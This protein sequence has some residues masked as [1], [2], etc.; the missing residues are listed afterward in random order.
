MQLIDIDKIVKDT[1]IEL[2][3]NDL[4]YNNFCYFYSKKREEK[5]PKYQEIHK[6]IF[7]K[8]LLYQE[9]NTVSPTCFE[10]K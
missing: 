1:Q 5:N 6:F 2:E 10:I 9:I 3:N 4:L 8:D 7:T